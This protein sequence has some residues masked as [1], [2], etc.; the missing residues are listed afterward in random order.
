MENLSDKWILS[1]HTAEVKVQYSTKEEK[2]ESPA[3]CSPND[4]ED[5]LRTIWN[6][7]IIE[8]RE[9][10]VVLFLNNDRRCLGWS[11]ISMGGRKATIVEPS[12]VLVLAL[13]TNASSVIVAHNH[14]GG[15]LK[16]STSDTHLTKRL[17]EGLF[18]IGLQLD[19]HIILTKSGY[20][21][22]RN[23]NHPP[24]NHRPS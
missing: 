20:Y 22:F 10:F 14:P 15:K 21:S 3:L 13:L 18:L 7:D 24:F 11:K 16:P 19:D 6:H 9:E 12:Q 2:G 1:P 17:Y 8:M 23:N 5:Y 4:V